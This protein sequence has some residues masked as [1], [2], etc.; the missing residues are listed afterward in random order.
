MDEK[1]KKRESS[2]YT[3]EIIRKCARLKIGESKPFHLKY[4]NTYGNIR[5]TL[6]YIKYNEGKSF[7]VNTK[8]DT[9][10]VTRIS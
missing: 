3:Q 6:S 4:W 7:S 9:L 2:L 10:I 8:S 5:K 1:Q